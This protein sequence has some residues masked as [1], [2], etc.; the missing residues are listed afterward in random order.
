MKILAVFTLI[1]CIFLGLVLTTTI[2]MFRNLGDERLSI[3][4][5]EQDIVSGRIDPMY[6]SPAFM[7]RFPTV[8]FYPHIESM[9]CPT[10]FIMMGVFVILGYLLV[11]V[12][13]RKSFL[14]V[15]WFCFV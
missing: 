15:G 7:D 13:L 3:N 1:F 4:L 5:T 14:H 12:Y 9:Y 8:P 6:V 2:D 11:R 10:P